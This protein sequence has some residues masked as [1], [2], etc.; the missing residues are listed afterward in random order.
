M[1]IKGE[2]SPGEVIV[3]SQL[4][5]MI[6]SPIIKIVNS[7][8]EIKSTNYIKEKFNIEYKEDKK[9]KIYFDKIQIRNLSFSYK[10]NIIFKKAN[11]DFLKNKKYLIV[12]KSG[13]GK[14]TLMKILLKELPYEGSIKI[15]KELK[16]ISFSSLYDLIVP[17]FQKTIIFND[18]IDFNIKLNEK[19]KNNLLD[20]VKEK[21]EIKSF[22]SN[23][24]IEENHKNFSTGQMQRIQLARA[25]YRKRNI[26]IL[27]E[28]FSSIDYENQLK[29]EKE[30]TKINATI[31][32][33][34]H[35]ITEKIVD[36]YDYVIFVEN[37]KLNL[38]GIDEA[39]KKLEENG[40]YEK[41]NI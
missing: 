9:E 21:T 4:T 13:E 16:D 30:L 28:A 3:A 23:R 31:I 29:I 41:D 7:Y 27:D 34:S 14:S 33:I 5:N 19:S 1:Y 25:F 38:F 10:N 35:R 22:Q 2:I 6:K 18:S 37:N 8:Y 17:V 11:I 32:N 36:L 12:G 24:L 26:F 40:F 39:K 15:N 20:I